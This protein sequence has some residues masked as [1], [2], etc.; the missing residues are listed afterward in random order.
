VVTL[1]SRSLALWML[2][3]L[4][5]AL[6]DAQHA[7]K[8]AREIGQAVTLMLALSQACL[9]DGSCG[10]YVAANA[11][12]DE[13]VALADQ[14]GT[15]Y[16]KAVGMLRQGWLLALGG[17]AADAVQVITSSL[18]ANRPMATLDHPFFLSSL[19]RAYAELG[20]LD[21]AWRSIDEALT[22]IETTKERWCEAE[23]NRTAGEIALKSPEPDA[24]KAEAYFER[25]LAVAGQQQAKSWELAPQRAWPGSGAIRA[26]AMR[27]AICSL[28]STAGSPKASIR[29]I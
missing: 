17:K 2:G 8:D 12:S 20:Q 13:L 14:K 16:W 19:A 1:S 11:L 18:T 4:E 7:L 5:A 27:P 29:S 10:N 15:R 6:A 28:R 22:L 24:A 23:V 3:Y 26:S 9:T 25:A 21:D